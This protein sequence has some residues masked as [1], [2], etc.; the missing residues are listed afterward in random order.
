MS[1]LNLYER[2]SRKEVR[3]AFDPNA[4]FTPGAGA[5]GLHGVINIS[6]KFEHF[7]FFVTYGREQSGHVFN[8]GIDETGILSWQS[9]PS[10]HLQERRVQHWITQN[11]NGC[12]ISLFVRNDKASQYIYLG[13]L[14]YLT[15]DTNKEKPVWF[16]FQ[17]LNWRYLEQLQPS[18]NPSHEKKK[19]SKSKKEPAENAQKASR[20]KQSG[21]FENN[22]VQL[23][24][25]LDLHP[26]LLGTEEGKEL[27]Y[28][29][30]TTM[31]SIIPLVVHAPGKE[32]FVVM[33]SDA[34]HDS[35]LFLEAGRLIQYSVELA[36]ELGK[37][38]ETDDVKKVLFLVG[39]NFPVTQDIA[40]NYNIILISLE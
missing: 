19:L 28:D 20:T 21:I 9:Q 5:W 17:I 14:S 12:K 38:L 7:V 18:I 10:Q 23:R 40:K 32:K 4:N 26:E 24:S 36:I 22:C 3:D 35:E 2:Y 39:G 6:S 8:E 11:K 13:E 25:L 1:N 29:Y 15:H 30:E 37:P 31:G 16:K 27:Q 34:S 33:Y